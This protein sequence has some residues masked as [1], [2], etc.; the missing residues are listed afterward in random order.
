[1]QHQDRAR[2]VASGRLTAYRVGP[3]MLR[4]SAEQLDAMVVAGEVPTVRPA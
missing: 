2:Y 3:T 1:V 4:V